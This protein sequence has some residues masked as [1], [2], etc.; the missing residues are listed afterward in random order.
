MKCCKTQLRI[1]LCDDS[2][3]V[4]SVMGHVCL[5][6]CVSVCLL[7]AWKG[8]LGH[9]VYFI[10]FAADGKKLVFRGVWCT[11]TFYFLCVTLRPCMC[12]FRCGVTSR[13]F[14]PRSTAAPPTWWW[15]CGSLCPSGKIRLKN[16]APLQVFLGLIETYSTHYQLHNQSVKSIYLLQ[17]KRAG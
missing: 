8:I 5:S 9:G 6:A 17:P 1:Y 14:S 3:G 4:Y 11:F 2:L 15:L 16:D 12:S 13:L 10:F 7:T